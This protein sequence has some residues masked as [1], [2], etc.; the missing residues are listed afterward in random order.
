MIQSQRRQVKAYPG[1]DESPHDDDGDGLLKVP[2]D[3]VHAH[4]APPGM[5]SCYKIININDCEWVSL[6]DMID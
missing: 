2:V 3:V 1:S 6:L 4:S 5:Y